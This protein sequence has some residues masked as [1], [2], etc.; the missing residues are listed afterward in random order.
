M[1][2]RRSSSRPLWALQPRAYLWYVIFITR[3]SLGKL[4]DD[5]KA[6]GALLTDLNPLQSSTAAASANI[7]RCALAATALAVLQPIIDG[8]GIGW[9]FTIFGAL[10]S[11][12]GPLLV[13]ELHNGC[14]YRRRRIDIELSRPQ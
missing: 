1:L 8:I 13:W 10:S 2:Q 3:P 6:L 9:C 4:T 5:G 12:C 14:H 7:V 11:M